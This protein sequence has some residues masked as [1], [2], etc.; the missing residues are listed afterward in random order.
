M[1][2]L[3]P[4][5]KGGRLRPRAPVEAVLMA[6]VVMHIGPPAGRGT[7]VSD[8]QHHR[9]VGEATVANWKGPRGL[10]LSFW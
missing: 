10:R 4:A 9:C 7:V 3:A 6:Q 1:G 2:R 8:T 5:R